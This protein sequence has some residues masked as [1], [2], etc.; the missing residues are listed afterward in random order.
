MKCE[1]KINRFCNGCIFLDM[2]DCTKNYDCS[3]QSK[4]I[5][6]GI[7][8]GKQPEEKVIC[9]NIKCKNWKEELCEID[10]TNC[11]IHEGYELLNGDCKQFAPDIDVATKQQS[12]SD[13]IREAFEKWDNKIFYPQDDKNFYNSYRED[14]SEDTTVRAVSFYAGFISTKQKTQEDQSLLVKTAEEIG[15]NK[16]YKKAQAEIEKLKR[17]ISGTIENIVMMQQENFSN[18]EILHEVIVKLDKLKYNK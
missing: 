12:T 8:T 11:R 7:G 10:K 3:G 14:H 13:E 4:Y 15:Y 9:L 5:N 17:L 1:N 18:S 2:D 16:G 6:C